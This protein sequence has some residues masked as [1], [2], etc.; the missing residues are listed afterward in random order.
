ML[1]MVDPSRV[2]LEV[3]EHAAVQDYA[4]LNGVL[5]GLQELGARLAI[6]DLGAGFANLR[7]LLRLKPDF[8]KLDRSLC[9]HLTASPGRALVAGVVSFAHEVG[10]DVIADR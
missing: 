3:T 8:V 9:R 10:A 1:R 7:H 4:A 5:D 6:D 2:V